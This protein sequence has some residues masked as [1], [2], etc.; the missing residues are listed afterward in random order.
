MTEC[1]VE[2]GIPSTILFWF[3]F[4]H[5]SDP[6]EQLKPEQIDL[7]SVICSYALFS[8]QRVSLNSCTVLEIRMTV[9]S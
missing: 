9:D 1:N 7:L 2:I 4:L 6:R 3:F 8:S 5:C